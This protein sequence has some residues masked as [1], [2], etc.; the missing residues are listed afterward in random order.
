MAELTITTAVGSSA[1]L[2]PPDALACHTPLHRWDAAWAAQLHEEADDY[3]T[4]MQ[5]QSWAH[6]GTATAAVGVVRQAEHGGSSTPEG[7]APV[8]ITLVLL[9]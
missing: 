8:R 9:E 7:T 2:P 6:L 5:G 3:R 1:V 4:P